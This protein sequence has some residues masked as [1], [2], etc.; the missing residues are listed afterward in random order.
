MPARD[1]CHEAVVKALMADGWTITDDPLRLIYGGEKLY[2]DLGA[3]RNAIAA[4]KGGAKIAVEIKSFLSRS[5]MQDLEEALGQFRLYLIVMAE[6]EPDRVLY[7]A[8]PNRVYEGLFCERLGQLILKKD[9][10]L[11]L[12]VFDEEQERI[13]TWVT[14]S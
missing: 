3:E 14:K 1:R 4:E 2:V 8:V 9:D 12:I 11:R 13:V 7:L 6:T 10:N 5:V